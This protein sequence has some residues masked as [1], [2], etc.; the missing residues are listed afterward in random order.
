MK[1]V[2]KAN[3]YF[4]IVMFLQLFL[5][6]HLIFKLF[7]ITDIKLM[8]FISHIVTF[9]FPAII[10]LIVTK[11]SARDVLKLN[12]LYFKDILLIILLA[13]VCQ[14]I[15]TFFSLISQ[16][17]FENEIG[18]FVTNIVESPYIVLLLLIAVLPAITEEITIRGIVLSGYE[19]KNIY[20]S[21][22]ITG[23]LF[24]IM[25]LDPQQFL[26]ATVLGVILAL[27]VRIT[28]SIFASILMHFLINGTSITLQKLL[29]LVTQSDLIVEQSTEISLKSL[30]IQEKV[31][32]A[33]FY[34]IIALA[35]GIVVYFI[36]KKLVD[37]NIKRGVINKSEFSVKYNKSNENVFN[38]SFIFII[39]FYLLYMILGV[40]IK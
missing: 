15:M 24:G 21:C 11:Q 7:N 10:Y 19:D 30:E 27:V 35:F 38:I 9:I 33:G 16:F 22:I 40:I 23:L 5:P 2:L 12:K 32:M 3:T 20:L 36:I 29:S 6:I 25:H 4:L 14:P 18:N 17:F 31:F 28:N 39:I 37:L 13:F 1:K 8:L 34:G 26:Y